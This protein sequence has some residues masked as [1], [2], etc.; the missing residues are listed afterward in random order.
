MLKRLLASMEFVFVTSILFQYKLAQHEVW[1]HLYDSMYAAQKTKSKCKF[2]TLSR[3]TWKSNI[4]TLCW[5]QEFLRIC[6]KEDLAKRSQD[7]RVTSQIKK[8]QETR[9]NIDLASFSVNRVWGQATRWGRNYSGSSDR[10]YLR[11]STVNRK[12]RR[13]TWVD[14]G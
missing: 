3:F 9:Y 8:N 6:R 12:G 2:V 7:M 13:Q 1:S 5:R 4:R 10:I 14:L 11:I